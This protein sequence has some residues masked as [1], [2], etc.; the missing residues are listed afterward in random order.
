MKIMLIGSADLSGKRIGGQY[1]KTRLIHNFLEKEENID[2]YFC[3]MLKVGKGLGLFWNIAKNY[4]KNDC[5]I[6]VTSTRGTKVITELLYWLSKLKKKIIVYL[7]VGNQQNLL[8]SF[9]EKK[10]KIIHKVYFEVPIMQE[11]LKNKLDVGFF[12]NCKDITHTRLPREY[13]K[14]IKICYYSEISYRKGFDR[15][16]RALDIVNEKGTEYILDVYGYFADDER[17]MRKYFDGRNFLNFKGVIQREK[18]HEILSKY[19]FMVFPSRHKLE[20]V[21]GAVVDA[22]EAGLPVMCS[23]VGFFPNVVKNQETGYIV[24][25]E[26]GIIDFLKYAKEN[27][28]MIDRLRAACRKEADK[29]DIKKSIKELHEDIINMCDISSKEKVCR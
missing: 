7:I 3:N 28:D 16:V 25:S 21:P 1:E 18:S 27:Q 11:E 23:D 10:L 8:K 19:F 17:E 26:K 6:A 12:S 9:S 5:I 22:F 2:L 14:P 13:E 15:I 24:D 20:G 4:M 29:Y